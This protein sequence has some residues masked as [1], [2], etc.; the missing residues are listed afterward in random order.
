MYLFIEEPQKDKSSGE[1]SIV[2]VPLPSLLLPIARFGSKRLKA[3]FFG[4]SGLTNVICNFFERGCHTCM[5][6]LPM[7]LNAVM[8][9]APQRSKA[10]VNLLQILFK[11]FCRD[12]TGFSR[13]DS[14]CLVLSIFWKVE[15]VSI[16]CGHAPR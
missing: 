4:E 2:I 8:W 6:I 3:P 1:E 13:V 11:R 9:L 12:K 16:E 15:G 7:V 5:E 10:V 14:V